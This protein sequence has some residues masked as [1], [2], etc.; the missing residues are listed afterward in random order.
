[1]ND[2]S[3]YEGEWKFNLRDGYGVQIYPSGD[4]YKGEFRN[5]LA[6]GRGQYIQVAAGS[7]GGQAT[8]NQKEG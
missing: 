6:N 2:G 4:T 8:F 5:G 7:S 3:K 1:M